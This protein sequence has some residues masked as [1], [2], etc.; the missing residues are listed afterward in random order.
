MVT[1]KRQDL[2]PSGPIAPE[3][4]ARAYIQTYGSFEDQPERDDRWRRTP[5]VLIIGVLLAVVV[6]LALFIGLHKTPSSGSH[7]GHH[8]TRTTI[9]VPTGFLPTPTTQ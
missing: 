7:G 3:E 6:V 8:A 2:N 5:G 4:V 9:T 1:H